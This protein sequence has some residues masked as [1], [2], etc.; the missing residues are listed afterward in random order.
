M[1][2][3]VIV[4]GE[5]NQPMDGGAKWTRQLIEKW[6]TDDEVLLINRG[7]SP[8]DLDKAKTTFINFHP[9]Y[10]SY[11]K[12]IIACSRSIRKNKNKIDRLIYFPLTIL[13]WWQFFVLLVFSFLSG[14]K[15]EVVVYQAASISPIFRLFRLNVQYL[16][17]TR[18]SAAQFRKINLETKVLEPF[19]PDDSQIRVQKRFDKTDIFYLGKLSSTRGA[20]VLYSVAD[21][22]RQGDFM[23]VSPSPGT[24]Y[25]DDKSSQLKNIT[26]L[27]HYLSSSELDKIYARSDYYIFL[28]NSLLAFIDLPLSVLRARK[29]KMT[30]IASDFPQLRELLSDYDKVDFIPVGKTSIMAKRVIN[31]LAHNEKSRNS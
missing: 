16:V 30:I 10:P 8:P 9:Q 6:V 4:N 21:G 5:L 26:V 7:F 22:F 19:V 25:Q 12:F 17:A 23:V 14:I 20:E 1:K 28:P 24:A 31:I 15:I 29:Y 11:L 3:L 27:R 13:K 2:I 18:W